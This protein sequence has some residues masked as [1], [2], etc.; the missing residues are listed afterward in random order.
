MDKK[1]L[2]IVLSIVG[3][4]IGLISLFSGGLIA[5]IILM[6]IYYFTTG[7]MI[8]EFTDFS[9]NLVMWLFDLFGIEFK[10]KNSDV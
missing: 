2:G 1:N 7:F 9:N 8:T 10:S 3:C 6:I 5:M 4:G